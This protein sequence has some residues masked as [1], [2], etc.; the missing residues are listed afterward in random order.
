[1][2]WV[3]DCV[4]VQFVYG[5]LSVNATIWQILEMMSSGLKNMLHMKQLYPCP[6]KA[7][8]ALI[9]RP[10]IKIPCPMNDQRN[11]AISFVKSVQKES[12]DTFMSTIHQFLCYRT[13]TE[14]Q[15]GSV[16]VLILV[17]SMWDQK[18]KTKTSLSVTSATASGQHEKWPE[19]PLEQGDDSSVTN[20]D[21]STLTCTATMGSSWW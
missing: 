3:F 17:H 20:L 15:E 2:F 21:T 18:D 9:V 4:R 14:P 12:L 10:S 11:Q 1:M 7:P 8:V 13:D 19:P 16:A 6:I 5:C